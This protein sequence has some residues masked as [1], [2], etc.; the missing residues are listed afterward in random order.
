MKDLKAGTPLDYTVFEVEPSAFLEIGDGS[1]DFRK[2]L[3]ACKVAGV[4]YAFL[5]QDHTALDKM[6]SV[7]KSVEYLKNLAL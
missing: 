2:I 1:I 6:E 4:Q 7:K 5:D 3:E